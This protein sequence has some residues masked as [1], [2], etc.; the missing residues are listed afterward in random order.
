MWKTFL[1]KTLLK[2]FSHS[3]CGKVVKFQKVPVEKKSLI[4]KDKTQFST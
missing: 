1:W 3:L 2:N 4:F